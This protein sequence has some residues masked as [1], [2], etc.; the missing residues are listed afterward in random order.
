MSG[1]GRKN[2]GG[3]RRKETDSIEVNGKRRSVRVLNFERKVMMSR[4]LSILFVLCVLCSVPL[5]SLFGR[6]TLPYDNPKH[7]LQIP[8]R[9]MI[10]QNHH[11]LHSLCQDILAIY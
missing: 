7:R 8:I 6:A 11:D 1:R 10:V 2:S 3:V 9:I 5:Y 4:I